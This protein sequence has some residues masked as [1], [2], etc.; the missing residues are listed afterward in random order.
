MRIYLADDAAIDRV[1]ERKKRH[2][3]GGEEVDLREMLKSILRWAN[4]FVPSEAGSILL[5]DPVLDENRRKPGRLYFMACFGKGSSRL[6]GTCVPSDAGIAGRCYRTGKAYMCSN[7]LSEDSS[8]CGRAG[9]GVRYRT[10]S[11]ICVPIQ[12]KGVT[13]GVLELINRKGDIDY[14]RRDLTLLKIFAGYTSTL[15]QNSLDAKRFSELSIKDNL[16]GLYN[17]RYFFERLSKEIRYASS[18]NRDLSLIFLDLDRFKEVNDTHGH[19]AG[20]QL[21]REVG[22]IFKSF[23]ESNLVPV[24]YGGD[25]FSVIMPGTDA[26]SAGVFAE[27]IRKAIESHV[28]LAR[29]VP[30][31]TGPLKIKNLITA[32]IGVASLKNNVG[33]R[34]KKLKDKREALIKAADTAMYTSKLKGKNRVTMA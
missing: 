4:E 12:I 30:G 14:D 22:N 26:E 31:Q 23:T 3:Y 24:R 18:R 13:I 9:T 2:E 6:A 5:D 17:D 7:A 16:T 1:L 25:E 19:L 34:H 20:S 27:K 15:I 32:S 10:K 28:F 8:Q 21:L 11:L 33:K 29:D